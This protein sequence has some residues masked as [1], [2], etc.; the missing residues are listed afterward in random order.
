MGKG[1]D[2]GCPV[3]RFISKTEIPDPH[4]V[5]LWC[6]VNG[7]ERQRGNTSD[8]IFNIPAL[9]SFVSQYMTLEPNDLILTGSAPGMGP[10]H[11]G[12]V[13]EGGIKDIVTIKFEVDDDK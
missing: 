5:E 10:V 12:D 1:F 7:Q 6:S 9:I 2:T 11:A 3:S 4:N 8:L 13:I